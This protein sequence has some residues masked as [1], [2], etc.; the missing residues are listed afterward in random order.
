VTV[1]FDWNEFFLTEKSVYMYSADGP[2][3]WDVAINADADS[4]VLSFQG[5]IIDRI[6]LFTD[7]I[8][9]ACVGPAVATL[10]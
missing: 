7:I 1:P 5:A 4:G 3:G 6:L 10:D 8:C 2:N 9:V